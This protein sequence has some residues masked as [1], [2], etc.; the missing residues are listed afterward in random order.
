MGFVLAPFQFAIGLVI[1]AV[2]AFL[3]LFVLRKTRWKLLLP[4]L[5]S[6][7]IIF[8]IL[9]YL[10]FSEVYPEVG[11]GDDIEEED[12]GVIRGYYSDRAIFEE[13]TGYHETGAAHRAELD[14]RYDLF[15]P[16][17]EAGFPEYREA[18]RTRYLGGV[19]GLGAG[20]GVFVFGVVVFLVVS[21]RDRSVRRKM[22]AIDL[23]GP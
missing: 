14:G 19:I 22:R 6:A 9:G 7:A 17:Y 18:E 4:V 5:A 20:G 13:Y 23:F 3:L 8:A 10:V 1:V 21:R 15:H 2:P 12:G 11:W 16:R